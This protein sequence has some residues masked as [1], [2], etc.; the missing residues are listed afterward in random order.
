MRL[1]GGVGEPTHSLNGNHLLNSDTS[2]TRVID[3]RHGKLRPR[4]P[5]TS[6]GAIDQR[7]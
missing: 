4:D 2:R 7:I 5:E 6:P 3:R 1:D